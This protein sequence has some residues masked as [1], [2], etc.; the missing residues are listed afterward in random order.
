MSEQ[1]K[2]GSDRN[3]T[4]LAAIAGGVVAVGA[5]LVLVFAPKGVDKPDTPAPAAAG[6]ATTDDAIVQ[7][8]QF[9]QSDPNAPAP[10]VPPSADGASVVSAD[11]AAISFADESISYSAALPSGPAGDPNLAYLRKDALSYLANKKAQAR[12]TYDEFKKEG[13]VPPT[14]PWEVMIQWEYTAKA[15]DIVSL[16]GSAYEYTGG[17]HGMTYFDTH[18]ARANGQQLQVTDMLKGGLTPAVV[19]AICEALKVEKKKRTDSET[20]YDE[21]IVCAGPNGNVKIEKAKLALA[22]SNQSGKFGGM[23]VYYEA[24]EVG[25]YAEGSYEF[26]VQQEVF[27][28]DLQPEFKPLF[29]GT[30]PPI[31]EKS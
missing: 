5:G 28:E 23:Q 11:G 7:T 6:E 14:F 18:V 21:P 8:A 20:I 3:N 19:I 15:G 24:Y 22:P 1:N 10:P 26:V 30:A 27:A 13:D 29:G 9:G 2:P 31:A 4:K 25:S 12:A 17:A 16:F